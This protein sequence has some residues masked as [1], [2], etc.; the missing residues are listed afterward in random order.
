MKLPFTIDAIA[1]ASGVSRAT[2][3]RF[4]NERSK[5]HPRTREH[6]LKMIE[7]LKG[8]GGPPPTPSCAGVAGQPIFNA[9]D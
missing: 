1:K 9:S 3:D 4:L 2:V 5:V 8:E 7:T 6:V